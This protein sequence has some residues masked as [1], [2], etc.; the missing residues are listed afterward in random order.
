[1]LFLTASHEDILG[2]EPL[3][4]VSQVWRAEFVIASGSYH[5]VAQLGATFLSCFYLSDFSLLS[6]LFTPPF[7]PLPLK[8][9]FSHV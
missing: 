8:Q 7:L 1:M 5:T 9:M 3:S 2:M 6:P 4:F